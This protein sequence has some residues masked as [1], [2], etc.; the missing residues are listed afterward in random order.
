VND[1]RSSY[2]AAVDGELDAHREAVRQAWGN[3]LEMVDAHLLVE[4]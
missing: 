4:D 3:Y 2:R 1:A